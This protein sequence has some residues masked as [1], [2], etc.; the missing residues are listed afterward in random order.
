METYLEKI[1]PIVSNVRR[2]DELYVKIKGNMKYMYALMDDETRFW[3]AQQVAHTKNTSDITPLLQ[4]GKKVTNM[5]PKTFISDGEYNFHTAYMKELHTL[6]NP[7]TR[8]IM[9]IRLQGDYNN[10]KMER[11]NGEVRD[12][13][14]TMRG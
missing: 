10:N 11:M 5:R 2:T 7:K 3:I 9:H 8:H 1:T 13:E 4:K 12:R 14:K 6:R